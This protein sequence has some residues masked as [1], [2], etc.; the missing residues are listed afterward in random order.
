MSNI[1]IE[2]TRLE[3]DHLLEELKFNT[4]ICTR[5]RKNALILWEK[6]AAIYFEE[7]IQLYPEDFRNECLGI[8]PDTPPEKPQPPPCRLIR[9][10]DDKD[11]RENVRGSWCKRWWNSIRNFC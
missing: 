5:N 10:S 8:V 4:R 6:I 11:I 3:C 2:L 9:E 1:N 7:E